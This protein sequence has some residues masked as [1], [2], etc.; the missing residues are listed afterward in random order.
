MLRLAR[1]RAGF[2]DCPQINQPADDCGRPAEGGRHRTRI[3][4]WVRCPGGGR[5]VF[6]QVELS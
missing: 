1:G 6:H 5:L 4:C 2:D 3:S